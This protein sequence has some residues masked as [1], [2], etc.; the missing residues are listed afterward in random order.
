MDESE[1]N[2][3]GGGQVDSAPPVG[4]V[5]RDRPA[6]PRRNLIGFASSRAGSIRS[7]NLLNRAL[8]DLGL[9][10]PR[11][12]DGSV[13]P[14]RWG[15]LAATFG[16]LVAVLLVWTS[17]HVVPPGTVGIPVT[18]GRTGD[19]VGSGV[20]ITWPLTTM[21]TVSTRT[22]NY[23]MSSARGEGARGDVDDSV[24]V[25]GADGGAA[26]VNA[27]VLF[28][29]DPKQATNLFRNVGS[30]YTLKLVR[31]G[32]RSCVRSE[33]TK[34]DMVDA[35]TSDWSKIEQRVADCMRSKIEPDGLIL[36]DFQ[37]REIALSEQLQ[38]AVNA[39]V[40]AQQNS[41][42]Q[43]F[44]LATAQQAADIARVNALATANS[45]QILACGGRVALE[46]REGKMVSVVL[47]NPVSE[48]SQAQLTPQYLQ[49]SYIQALKGLADSPNNTFIILPF[50]QA[51]TPL[52]NLDSSGNV[53]PVSPP[54]T[55][56]SGEGS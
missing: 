51:L 53:T 3:S 40:A 18:L 11:L 41:L 20:R 50:D 7:G 2:D 39:K 12:D 10:R 26:Q 32:A 17:L 4:G 42:Q 23:T 14:R 31:P 16:A 22:Q 30:D 55:S 15:R 47:P 27:T 33:F 49:Y 35:A 28:S 37:L 21:N 38:N 54:S 25:L 6:R 9:R 44:E 46:E 45:Q 34:S 13:G 1:L 5:V 36:L 56:G 19:V 24:P 43:R 29:V 52:L 8:V 48:C